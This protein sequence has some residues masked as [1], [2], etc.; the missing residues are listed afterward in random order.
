M[1]D[2]RVGDAPY[3]RPSYPTKAPA[4]QDYEPGAQVLSQ[5]DDGLIPPFS[6][7]KVGFF[8]GPSSLFDLSN[9]LVEHLLSFSLYRIECLFVGFV[10]QA[11]FAYV[12]NRVG[13]SGRDGD[14]VKL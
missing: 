6:Y 9:L 11:G 12:I 13:V 10:A 8:N 7:P 14:D 5:V 2:D 1:A 3:Q 4:T